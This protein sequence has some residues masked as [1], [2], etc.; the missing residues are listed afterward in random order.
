MEVHNRNKLEE[1]KAVIPEACQGGEEAEFI[2]A[3]DCAV[4]KIIQCSSTCGLAWVVPFFFVL[5][6]CLTMGVNLTLNTLSSSKLFR[7]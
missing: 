5:L 7:L 4:S 1:I 3:I 6:L 2:Q